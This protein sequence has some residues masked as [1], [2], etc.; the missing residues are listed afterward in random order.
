M[1]FIQRLPPEIIAQIFN[2]CLPDRFDQF[3]SPRPGLRDSDAPL[4]LTRVCSSWRAI[5]L[6]CPFLWSRLSVSDK[7]MSPKLL[8][9]IRAW[10]KFSNYRPVMDVSLVEMTSSWNNNSGINR[11]DFWKD[12]LQVTLLDYPEAIQSLNMNVHDVYKRTSFFEIPNQHLPNLRT[13]QLHLGNPTPQITVFA[14]TPKLRRVCLNF[15][16]PDFLPDDPEAIILPWAQLTHLLILVD[17]I[18]PITLATAIHRCPDLEVLSILIDPDAEVPHRSHTG[19]VVAPKLSKLILRVCQ[20][21]PANLSIFDQVILPA[22]SCLI[23]KDDEESHDASS[24]HWTQETSHFYDQIHQLRMLSLEG[25]MINLTGTMLCEVL[26]HTPLLE[27]LELDVVVLG[28]TTL[29]QRLTHDDNPDRRPRDNTI[30]D[31]P[32]APLLHSFSLHFDVKLCDED[33]ADEALA[34]INSPAN[35]NAHLTAMIFSRR[36]LSHFPGNASRD[37][38]NAVKTP[39]VADLGAVRLHGRG[40]SVLDL[41]DLSAQVDAIRWD[42]LHF[43]LQETYLHDFGYYFWTDNELRE[44]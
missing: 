4:V 12:L 6:E 11:E 23:I 17:P 22:L 32:L 30:L 3:G 5:A 21:P 41:P 7:V 1:S 15:L 18:A 34:I 33:N 37:E 40:L 29:L 25:P 43:V 42:G 19:R 35:F 31:K 24:F 9:K 27:V 16:N 28:F 8:R 10:Y 13:L 39:A 20:D 38:D 26:Q 44:W 2:E 14:M 36:P